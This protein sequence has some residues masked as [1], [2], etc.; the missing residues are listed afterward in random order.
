MINR[1]PTVWLQAFEAADMHAAA[2]ASEDELRACGGGALGVER[3]REVIL[4]ARDLPAERDRWQRLLDPARPGP[5]GAWQL[6]DGPALRLVADYLDR[7]Q[8]LVCEVSSL[9]H[10][11]D[12]LDREG[13]L[14]HAPPGE[15]RV[16][17]DALQ[18]IDLRLVEGAAAP[19]V[20]AASRVRTAE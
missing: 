3:V 1:H 5:D 10:A 17:P 11:R 20:N 6:G 16:T 15:L 7:I 8:A 2:A 13:V 14:A 9:A 18:G 19:R 4:G 12:F